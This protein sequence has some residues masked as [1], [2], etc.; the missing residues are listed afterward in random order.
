MNAKEARELSEKSAPIYL[1]RLMENAIKQIRVEAEIG[2]RR[3]LIH[4]HGWTKEVIQKLRDMGYQIHDDLMS[5][6]YGIIT[7]N[8]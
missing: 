8:W 5:F 1:Q 7:V 6:G 4:D 2:H 3:A